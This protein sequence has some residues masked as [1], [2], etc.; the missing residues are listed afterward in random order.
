MSS[1]SLH[2]LDNE[3]HRAC[4]T[5]EPFFREYLSQLANHCPFA[6]SIKYVP[7]TSLHFDPIVFHAATS[8]T[9]DELQTLTIQPLSARFYTSFFAHP[10]FKTAFSIESSLSPTNAD[11]ESCRL[12]V[13]DTSLLDKLLATA[14]E[15]VNAALTKTKHQQR[16]RSFEKVILQTPISFLRSSSSD[17]IMD[18]F[19]EQNFPVP[20]QREYSASLLHYLLARRLP[21]ESQAIVMLGFI[22]ARTALVNLALHVAYSLWSGEPAIQYLQS[23][24]VIPF[25]GT[26]AYAGW[27]MIHNY[28]GEYYLNPFAWG[29]GL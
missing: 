27:D 21:V 11:Q 24:S 15:N 17:Q 1:L 26:L 8:P 16:S 4:S 14:G 29:E 12:S 19:V 25:T 23:H 9:S 18:R 28:V 6:L 20:K 7:L 10:D 3:T 13:S 22:M 2:Q 5:L